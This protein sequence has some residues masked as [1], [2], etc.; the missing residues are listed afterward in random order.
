MSAS[1]TSWPPSPTCRTCRIGATGTSSRRAV[2]AQRRARDLAASGLGGASPLAARSSRDRVAEDAALRGE[3]LRRGA[4]HAGGIRGRPNGT[5]FVCARCSGSTPRPTGVDT[6]LL[7]TERHSRASQDS[8]L[9]RVSGLVPQRG[10]RPLLHRRDPAPNPAEGSRR[11]AERGR[12][13]PLETPSRGR[14]G[15][16]RA[17]RRLRCGRAP[18][19]RRGGRLRRASAVGGGTR[20][21]IFEASAMGKAVVSTSVGAEGLPIIAERA[22]R[23]R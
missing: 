17:R 14:R 12:P 15:G 23:P 18:A 7:P 19:R 11:R 1:P 22:L 3:G 5:R 9:H 16:R 10:R 21:K 4:P 8:G 2:R 13:Q 20:L 6:R